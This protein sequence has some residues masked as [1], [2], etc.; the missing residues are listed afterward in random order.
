M[1]FNGTSWVNVGP[2]GFSPSQAWDTDLDLDA[3]GTPYVA[4]RVVGGTSPGANVMKFDGTNWVSVG[5][6]G[7]SSGA[8][9]FVSIVLDAAGIPYV[10][11]RDVF[12]GGNVEVKKFNGSSWV[13]VT[14]GLTTADVNYTSLD[15]YNN[16]LYLAYQD[17]SSTFG[18]SVM[19][20]MVP[21]GV[22]ES[23]QDQNSNVFP[24]PLVSSARIILSEDV[25]G[26]T[27][28]ITDV[29]GRAIV[30]RA[31]ING[32]QLEI[33]RDEMPSSGVYLY[34]VSEGDQVI[35]QGKFL[36]N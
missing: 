5:P 15:R 1:K 4:L 29:L 36:V 8:L 7:F 23:A 26:A 9:F 2:A 20:Y 13:S 6:A 25:M 34:K 35:A 27:L 31:G 18:A 11:Y 33:A 24:N 32:D 17:A 10:S 30:F 14:T 21:A 28:E 3:S 16:T 12:S 19:E 22:N